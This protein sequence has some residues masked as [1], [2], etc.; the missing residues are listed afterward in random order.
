MIVQKIQQA[1]ARFRSKHLWKNQRNAM[2]LL[3]VQGAIFAVLF[4]YLLLLL[5]L[6]YD[7]RHQFYLPVV[8]VDFFLLAFAMVLNTHGKYEISVYITVASVM[9]SPWISILFDPAVR[10]GDLIPI[11]YVGLSVQGCAVLLKEKWVIWIAI[12]EM[13]GVLTILP[14]MASSANVNWLSLFAFIL[15]TSA[16]AVSYGYTS[17]KQLEQ[18]HNLS[19]RDSLTGLFN[20]RYM[21]ETFDREI[22]RIKRN[23][24]TLCVIMTDVD[25]FKM[26]NDQYGHVIGDQVL[27][28]VAQ[29]ITSKTRDSDIVCRYGGD[30][31]ILILLECS[32]RE[33]IARS[34]EIREL[35]AQS[36][37]E[38]EGTSVS[39]FTLSF[40]IAE[41]S[42][43]EQTRED[44]I[45]A[46]D[47]ALYLSKHNGRNRVS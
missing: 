24:Q 29:I 17:R 43:A 13:L 4:F 15:C 3:A 11:L 32:K 36:A 30:E 7:V 46:A 28:H 42:Q 18:I 40:G 37:L 41:L 31:F 26:I 12:A 16:I 33:A 38:L 25:R 5:L 22:E 8:A 35:V 1:L 19:V 21:E 47:Q 10:Q 2:S 45:N 6:P 23:G 34:E 27:I 39:N 44:L 14:S 9:I 20:R